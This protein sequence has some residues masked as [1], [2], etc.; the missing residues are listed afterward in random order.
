M[1]SDDLDSRRKR[2]WLETKAIAIH[3][4]AADDHNKTGILG[5]HCQRKMFFGARTYSAF[6]YC[7]EG[8]LDSTSKIPHG[9]GFAQLSKQTNVEVAFQ[10]CV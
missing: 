4:P 8:C 3:P 1:N 5:I 6:Q 2:D 10:K 9:I 7:P